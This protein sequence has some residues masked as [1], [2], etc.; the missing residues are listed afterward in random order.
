MKTKETIS[1]PTRRSALKY[2]GLVG[3]TA[4]G[5]TFLAGWL[6]ADAL[7]ARDS[8]C[9]AHPEPLEEPAAPYAPQFFQPA[10]F[11][12]VGLL[13][14]MILPSDGTPGAREARVAEYIDFVVYSAAEFQPSLQR[15]WREGLAYLDR[16][17]AR[18]FSTP[19]CEVPEAERVRLLEEMSVPERD[20]ARPHEGFAF[21]RVLK[22]MTVEGFYTSKIGLIDVLGYQGMNYQA[23]FPG[24][25]H[26]EHQA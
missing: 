6:P 17:S 11:L 13:T 22:E 12:T 18:R 4:A 10:E 26:P 7:A 25:T 15:E 3:A 5:R 1:L 8:V 16:E 23:D 20:P 21:F 14:E 19:F 24:C 9:H 2:L